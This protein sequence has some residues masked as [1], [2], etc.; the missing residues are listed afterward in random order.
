MLP[1]NN[2]L[3]RAAASRTIGSPA[4]SVSES[5]PH[6]LGSYRPDID[7][8]RA[9][10][11][12]AVL[13]Y[14]AHLGLPGGFIGVDVFFVISGFLITS[15][16]LKDAES[17]KG[18][19]ILNFWERRIRRIL[20]ALLV[21]I[22]ATIAGGWF[23][24]LPSDF[25][26]L[27]RSVLAQAV[28]GGN[29][30]FWLTG[31]YFTAP[32]GLKP[33]L[34][35]WSLAVE[36]QYYLFFPLLFLLGAWKR[37]AL[38]LVVGLA[39]LASFFLCV[40]LTRSSPEAGFYLLPSRAWELFGGALLA[41]APQGFKL[42]GWAREALGWGGLLAV[43]C[44][45][46]LYHDTTPFPGV[47]ALPPCLGTL[48]MIYANGGPA[49]WLGRALSV[50]PLVF[51]GKI[52]YSLYLWHWPILVYAVYWQ[53]S[54]ILRWYYRI[55][56]LVLSVI[57]AT[58]SCK[59]VEMPFRSRRVF[60]RRWQILTLGVASPCCLALLGV[61]LA[62]SHGFPSRFPE[63][64]LR[65]DFGKSAALE[66]PKPSLDLNSS[67]ETAQSG[68]F[69]CA[70]KSN[71]PV[72]CLVWGDSHAMA[73]FPAFDKLAMDSGTR[74]AFAAHVATCPVLDYLSRDPN[75]MRTASAKWSEAI[76]NDVQR[77][78]IPNVV[79]AANWLMYFG[80]FE[81]HDP[82]AVQRGREVS[83]D[84]AA[85]VV[86]LRKAGAKV[87]ILK[88]VPPQPVDVHMALAKAALRNTSTDIGVT[89]SNYMTFSRAEDALFAP[90][91]SSGAEILDP[92]RFFFEGRQTCLLVSSDRLLYKDSNHV[93][94]SGALALLDLFRPTV[95]R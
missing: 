2:A 54:N 58:I 94:I 6:A 37:A 87:W 66:I 8:L 55:A 81:T 46:F 15:L 75:S 64:V 31:G 79:L 38:R 30:Y 19:G 84:L 26:D 60:P 22:L 89:K 88:T 86:A 7:G 16:I 49:S 48:M 27:G 12:S 28:F 61:A 42:A 23:V 10:A 13:L 77:D 93:T 18:F 41:M 47:A 90:A 51:L 74:V 67:L 82:A 63:S 5:L 36:E 11:V 53:D 25:S 70:G 92:S 76:V 50:R 69:P 65:C 73:I 35:T 4:D 45:L 62:A 1:D 52:S 59:F 17:S 78:R 71:S 24:L 85:T 72:Q 95:A 20:P 33:L 39:A 80:Q 91:V 9:I 3:K 14:H 40:S 57:L 21:V 29:F 34:H 44:C 32:A 56:L 83:K 43:G 68:A